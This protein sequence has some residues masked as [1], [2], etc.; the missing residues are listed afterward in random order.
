MSDQ[1]NTEEVVEE[2]KSGFFSRLKSG[3]S[4]TRNSLA[5]GIDRVV[6]GQAKVGPELLDELEEVLISADVGV[7][8]TGFIL[9]ELKKGVAEARIRDNE[10][11]LENLKQLMAGILEAPQGSR[12]EFSEPPHVVLVI[13][14]NGSGKTTTIG[15]L[16]QKWKN[17]GKNVLL[18]AGD[19]FRAA[20]VEQML[21][22]AERVGVPCIH[23]K[24]GADP[25][26]VAF[27]AVQAAVARKMDV[28]I[29]DTAGRLQTNTNLMEELKK[30]KRVI[31]KV[32]P[33]APHETLLVLD[34]SIGQ[35]SVSQAKLFHEA[36]DIDG[37]VMTKLDGTGKGGVLLNIT[38]EL[39]L[40]VRYI[41]IG[42]KAED[43]QEFDPRS[44]VDAL[45]AS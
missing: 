5:G 14:V 17:E 36:M 15:K 9:E 34:A 32:L 31:G 11:I 7:A 35:N 42:E 37:L 38:R 13:G 21:I 45:F 18:G 33:D 4:K 1:E 29:I 25:S 8:T 43:L 24:T 23:Q 19:T 3:L 6:H 26:A 39:N 28:A 40:P 41:G 16:T 10:G 12:R 20:A 22:W 44:F 27:D 30:V 2:K